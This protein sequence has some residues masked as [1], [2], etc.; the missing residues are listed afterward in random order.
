MANKDIV[1]N[2]HAFTDECVARD[3]AAFSNRGIL[4]DFDERSDFCFVADFT[5][6]EVDKLREPYVS[7]QPHIISD[8]QKR[9]HFQVR[10]TPLE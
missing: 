3:L 4:L 1:F 10:S 8:A 5:A 6:I 7:T 9:I 2:R